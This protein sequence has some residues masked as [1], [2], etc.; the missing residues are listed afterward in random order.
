MLSRNI[1][2]SVLLISL[3]AV[4]PSGCK[5]TG[6]GGVATS[7]SAADYSL[8]RDQGDHLEELVA[9]EKFDDAAALY[10]Q[11]QA[12]FLAR[13]DKHRP[14]LETVAARLN[15][16]QA[17]ALG[18][19]LSAIDSA[20]WP[21][22]AN[23]WPNIKAVLSDADSAGA[24]YN[25]HLLLTDT[26][27]SSKLAVDLAARATALE[28]RIRAEAA[29]H[30]A[31]FN[32][33]G[34]ASFFDL[35]P[36]DV[37][38]DDVLTAAM[39]S[40][41]DRLA[42]ATPAEIRQFTTRYPKEMHTPEMWTEL[43]NLFVAAS[44]RGNRKSTSKYLTRVLAALKD[45]HEIGFTPQKLDG[46]AIGF[47][48]VTSRSLLKQG[49]IEFPAEVAV[50]LPVDIAKLELDKALSSPLAKTADYLIVFD[51]ALAKTRRKISTKKSLPSRYVAGYRTQPNP[52]YSIAQNK[53][54]L[55][56]MELQELRAMERSAPCQGIGCLAG[57]LTQLAIG[58]PVKMAKKK[59]TDAMAALSSTPMT[60]DVPVMRKYRY[61][62]AKI[63]SS[64]TMT[65]HY[66]I[67]DRR[68]RTYFKST[69]DVTE[70]KNFDVPYTLNRE[71]P[72]RA[73]IMAAGDSDQ[74]V[75]DWEEAP[76]TVRLTQLVD[77]YL[78][79]AG[80]SKPLPSAA[81]LRRM[82]LADK[83]AALKKYASTR[84]DA[85]PLNDPRFDSVVV[86][87]SKSSDSASIG[88][89]FFVAPDLVLTN[90]HVLDGVKFVEMKTYDGQ[91]TFGKVVAQDLIRDL[92]IVKVQSRGKPVRLYTG[93][94]ID[95]G[96]TVEAIGH[97]KGLEFSITRGVISALR[98]QNTAV[99]RG[100]GGEVLFIQTDSPINPGNSGGPLFQG[101]R[102]V[103]VNTEIRRNSEGL[104]FA[105]HYSEVLHF[106]REN[107]PGFSTGTDG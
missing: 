5:T 78:E 24:K 6:T 97:P 68:E 50:D 14:Q 77:H 33:A 18:R 10:A 81:V 88:S 107:V 26:R 86:V 105:V 104:N 46:L 90:F 84:F 37:S 91:E 8:F 79:N 61:D 76:S 72:D 23:D 3:I 87:Y 58:N 63:R 94:K 29:M 41:R 96:A 83:N 35:Y 16:A 38:A 52:D 102:V 53:V 36:V 39:P 54:S 15:A 57:A 51:V 28:D 11:H 47:I 89:G 59:L 62:Q 7:S 34:P 13:L 60:I 95:L 27:F 85:R 25:Q 12:Y 2:C 31:A 70:K 9:A 106:L 65:V 101:N 93:N 80:R 99:S 67:L 103:G 56:H 30:F 100:V 69:F 20:R 92:A 22:D 49:Q 48:E 44:L 98:K 71:D 55:A 32:H 73:K 64:K 40:L 82:M 66:Y 43:G 19:A 45:A 42:R 17:P 4:A 21:A 75:A 1:P 74:S